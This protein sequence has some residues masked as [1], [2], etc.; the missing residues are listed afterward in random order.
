MLRRAAKKAKLHIDDEKCVHARWSRVVAERRLDRTKRSSWQ[1]R[2][3]GCPGVRRAAPSA[4]ATT[5]GGDLGSVRGWHIGRR[6]R[7]SLRA[8]EHTRP[9]AV[10]WT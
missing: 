4:V 2:R 5:G 7:A 10:P 9:T 3:H 6:L 1:P 8:M